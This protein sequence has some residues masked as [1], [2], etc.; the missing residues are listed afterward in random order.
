[1][2]ICLRISRDLAY[3]RAM[4]RVLAHELY[5]VLRRTRIH[6]ASRLTKARLAPADLLS[7][8]AE[9]GEVAIA[10]RA[11]PVGFS[12]FIRAAAHP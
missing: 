8:S 7:E 11:D 4:A 2:L 6:T 1:M 3:G 10:K 5:H 9:Y 12:L